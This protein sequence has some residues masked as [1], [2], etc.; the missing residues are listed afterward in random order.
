VAEGV[1]ASEQVSFLLR[2]QIDLMQG[3]FFARPLPAEAGGRALGSGR[4]P[5]MRRPQPVA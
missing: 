1:S 5:P 2:H 3:P 4:L